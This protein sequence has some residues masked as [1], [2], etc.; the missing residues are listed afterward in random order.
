[1]AGY[2]PHRHILKT[3]I[4]ERCVGLARIIERHNTPDCLGVCIEEPFSGQF[5]SVKALFPMLGAAVLTCERLGM[6]WSM[7][8]L[9]KLKKHAI[10]KCNATKPDMQAA[11]KARW[12]FDLSEDEADAAWAGAFALDHSLFA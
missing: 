9:S 11:A 1:M 12:G 8:N 5:S 2:R 10:G 6:P 7:V 4:N 3:S